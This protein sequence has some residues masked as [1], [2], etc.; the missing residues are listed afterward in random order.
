MTK[1]SSKH[2]LVIR[3]LKPVSWLMISLLLAVIM[4]SMSRNCFMSGLEADLSSVSR[5]LL[6]LNSSSFSFT[7]SLHSADYSRQ[8]GGSGMFIPD[9]TFFHPGS[10]IPDPNCLHP[11]SPI[12]I[13]EFKYFN[14]QKNK[15]MFSK[16]KKYDLGCSSQIPDPDPQH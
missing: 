15:K 12:L 7:R 2:N 5:F 13:Q 1:I 14:P 8:C 10:R 9:P 4:F 11:R 16:L 6:S 3:A